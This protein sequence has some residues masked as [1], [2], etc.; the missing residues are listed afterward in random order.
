MQS[1]SVAETRQD[2]P[3]SLRSWKWWISE[4]FCSANSNI[5][6]TDRI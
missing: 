4:V 3:D 2:A 6:G 5:G 1:E